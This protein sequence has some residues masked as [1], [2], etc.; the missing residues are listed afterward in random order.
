MSGRWLA[1][2]KRRRHYPGR[3]AV[4]VGL[5]GALVLIGATFGLLL[6]THTAPPSSGVA[7]G[8]RRAL[9][10]VAAQ[11]RSGQQNSPAVQA[12][13]GQAEH[14][15]QDWGALMWC[16]PLLAANGGTGA[17]LL[18]FLH[19]YGQR[20]VP[21]VSFSLSALEQSPVAQLHA[22]ATISATMST[23]NLQ[24]V[25]AILPSGVPPSQVHVSAAFCWNYVAYPNV[26]AT[27]PL[28]P[29]PP[30]NLKTINAQHHTVSGIVG[31]VHRAMPKEQGR[32]TSAS[33][34]TTIE[35]GYVLTWDGRPHPVHLWFSLPIFMAEH[36]GTLQIRQW[37]PRTRE[38][39]WLRSQRARA[40]KWV[41]PEP[42]KAWSAGTP[43][44]I[45]ALAVKAHV[46]LP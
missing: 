30:I 40:A 18:H 41:Y 34:I 43:S 45:I 22:G 7:P 13:I 11:P 31:A 36:L 32:P 3:K 14:A 8:G 19:M 27:K 5:S 24:S 25:R 21:Y 39:I 20:L 42:H 26:E 2:P 12:A 37:P 35:A 33:T 9:T 17:S 23:A 10:R 4:A 16:G 1:L 44:S 15:A 46:A 38:A 28:P 29:G 6:G